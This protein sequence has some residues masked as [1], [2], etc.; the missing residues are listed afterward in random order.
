LTA[1]PHIVV[2]GAGSIGCFIGGAW[3]A[4]GAKVSFLGRE[5]VR[6]EIAANGL[7]AQRL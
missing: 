1:S 6:D 5:S 2:M 7:G 4:G 3:Q